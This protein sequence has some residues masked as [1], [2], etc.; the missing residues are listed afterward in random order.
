MNSFCVNNFKSGGAPAVYSLLPPP[1]V[2]ET[3]ASGTAATVGTRILKK[4]HA[5]S[6]VLTVRVYIHLLHGPM[7]SPMFKTTRVAATLISNRLQSFPPEL[8]E[9]IH[10]YLGPEKQPLLEL[11]EIYE[12]AAKEKSVECD[13]VR[14]EADLCL[15]SLADAMGIPANL[16]ENRTAELLSRM[17]TLAEKRIAAAIPRA[18]IRLKR[19]IPIPPVYAPGPEFNQASTL[20]RFM[21]YIQ[22]LISN[23]VSLKFPGIAPI[24]LNIQISLR[25]LMLESALKQAT[26]SAASFDLS[27]FLA[28]IIRAY[29]V[30]MNTEEYLK[31][32]V[33]YEGIDAKA[34]A[35]NTQHWLANIVNYFTYGHIPD[36]E[37]YSFLIWGGK[38]HILGNQDERLLQE[39]VISPD[40]WL[41]IQFDMNT[42]QLASDLVLMAGELEIAKQRNGSA[43]APANPSPRPKHFIYVIYNLFS[44]VTVKKH[45]AL[46]QTQLKAFNEFTKIFLKQMH[47]EKQDKELATCRTRLF[48]LVKDDL[49]AF[50]N[51]M[52]IKNK[53]LREMPLEEANLL[54]WMQRR[55]EHEISQRIQEII[56]STLT[57]QPPISVIV[58]NYVMKW[59]PNIS[60][61]SYDTLA[62]LIM[63]QWQLVLDRAAEGIADPDPVKRLLTKSLFHR[64][65][66]INSRYTRSNIQRQLLEGNMSPAEWVTK[67]MN[68]DFQLND[69]PYTSSPFM[70]LLEF[71]KVLKRSPDEWED[72]SCYGI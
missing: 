60:P 51:K 31:V 44:S 1:P 19:R 55:A 62:V 57:T 45:V 11:L 42:R 48:A 35:K 12:R 2:D 3:A 66:Y 71:M 70:R 9:L 39:G 5:P 36:D 47:G 50:S 13:C 64:L 30:F 69:M 46:N 54:F 52:V 14:K 68:I 23:Y 25:M 56:T 18:L 58:D 53:F 34:Y 24:Q 16:V 59:R 43:G 7:M 29:N 6:K 61:A 40:E 17:Q 41:Q 63:V 33:N 37:G 32:G 28:H 49:V 8:L 15:A 67:Y 38:R 21:G 72:F 4:K 27:V 65:K 20:G 22:S 26:D 10:S